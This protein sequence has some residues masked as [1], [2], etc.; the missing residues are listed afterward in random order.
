ML[1]PGVAALV[2]ALLLAAPPVPLDSAQNGGAFDRLYA[3]Y[4]AGDYTVIQRTLRTRQDFN[5]IRPDLFSAVG[6]WKGSWQRRPVVFLLD[7]ATLALSRD[8]L[9]PMDPLMAARDLVR[10]RPTEPGA[11]AEDDQFETTFHKTAVAVLLAGSFSD[12]ADAYLDTLRDRVIPERLPTSKA[13]L[14]EPR[15]TLQR[16]IAMEIRTRPILVTGSPTRRLES[17]LTLYETAARFPANTPEARVR[18]A[19]I[20]L[21][22][23]HPG[24]ALA[25]LGR[26]PAGA[27]ADVTYW[28]DIIRGRAEDMRGNTDGALAAYRAAAAAQ[29]GAQSSAAALSALL[30]RTGQA[31]EAQ[32]WAERALRAPG[33][34]I[35][36]WWRYW[37]ADRRL[38]T[39]WLSDLRRMSQ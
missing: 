27:D 34:T 11:N 2:C 13:R 20:H 15:L 8:W 24:E 9:T 38:I 35:D 19:Y 26:L 29:P 7:L 1:R 21:R 36:P 28:S 39:A 16:A 37:A 4:A 18:R 23:E 32:R 25:E 31:D 6:R 10:G 14:I 17:A 12:A 30:I 33:T 3:S 22:L 5:E